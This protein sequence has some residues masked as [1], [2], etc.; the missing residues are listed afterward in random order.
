MAR[1]TFI[2]KTKIVDAQTAFNAVLTEMA[3]AAGAT[4]D[5]A[6]KARNFGSNQGRLVA[7]KFQR[8]S[9]EYNQA[10]SAAAAERGVKWIPGSESGARAPRQPKAKAS[11]PSALPPAPSTGRLAK[12]R[13]YLGRHKGKAGIVAG[14]LALGGGASMYARWKRKRA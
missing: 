10:M 11:A 9:P 5:E 4:P 8:G 13:E 2:P 6:K 3:V 1:P 7:K 12:V 14:T